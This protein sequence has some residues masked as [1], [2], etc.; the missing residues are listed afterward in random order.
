MYRHVLHLQHDVRM[1]K[2]SCVMVQLTP[3][4]TVT[5]MWK[6]IWPHCDITS[7]T[8]ETVI[9][10]YPHVTPPTT[11]PCCLCFTVIRSFMMLYPVEVRHA[12]SISITVWTSMTTETAVQVVPLCS[13]FLKE[14]SPVGRMQ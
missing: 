3:F 11:T 1:F 6:I 10:L 13:R 4:P 12:T 2:K 5:N 9:S 14:V 8:L 7:V